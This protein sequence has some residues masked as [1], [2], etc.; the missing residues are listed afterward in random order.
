MNELQK[1]SKEEIPN[2][3]KDINEL[4]ILHNKTIKQ[5]EGVGYVLERI[6]QIN[7]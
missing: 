1:I 2:N 6:K 4:P 3:L 5:E 7:D